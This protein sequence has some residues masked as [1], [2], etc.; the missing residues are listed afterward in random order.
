MRR[1]RPALLI[2]VGV[3]FAACST[4]GVDLSATTAPA[5]KVT[6]TPAPTAVPLLIQ[7]VSV[8]E[9]V[10]AGDAAKVV[11]TTA[12]AAEC[13]IKV[14]YD[15]G[16][17]QASGLEAQTA[18]A[19]GKVTWSWTVGRTTKAGTWPIEIACFKGERAGTL[20]LTFAVR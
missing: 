5:P 1:G 14:T 17:S 10:A 19:A 11:I 9:S 15:S 13:T 3:V 7:K 18:D 4:P 16:P 20:K 2:L 12:D 8:T 6:P